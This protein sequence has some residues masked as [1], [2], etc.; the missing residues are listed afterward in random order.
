MERII[1]Y[2]DPT[3]YAAEAYR[4]ICANMLAALGEKKIVEIVALANNSNAS[5]ITANLAVAIAQA[6]KTVLLAD[7]NLRNPQ[8]HSLFNIQNT[9]ITDCLTV[10]EDY[11]SFVQTTSQHNLYVLTAGS[12]MANNPV[13]SL[14]SPSMQ[15]IL[16]K[17]RETY[18]VILVEVPPVGT[19]SDAIS[20]GMKTDGVLLVFT[21]KKDKV[22]QAQK[23]KEMFIQAGVPVLGCILDKA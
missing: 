11:I 20:L 18:E 10:E 8:Q 2:T 12:I 13:E 15:K 3:G 4:K 16:L 5:M 7:C 17:A 19:V 21:N 14:L 23:A 6:G 1:M 22:E 9:G